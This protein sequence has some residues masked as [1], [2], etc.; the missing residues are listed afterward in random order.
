MNS[1]SFECPFPG[2]VQSYR[3]EKTLRRHI[4]AL[5]S[6]TKLFQCS[7]CQKK[8]SSAQNLREHVYIHTGERPY[9]CN[10]PG[11]FARFRQGS[12]LS[13]HKKIHR[14]IANISNR[15][16]FVELKVMFK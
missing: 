9:Q 2:C 4:E 12:Q 8:M 10:Q 13:A 7:Y 3:V 1:N 11:C 16:S 15:A 5:H 14:E 6:E